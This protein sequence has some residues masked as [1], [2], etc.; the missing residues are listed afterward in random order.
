MKN[1]DNEWEER[2][3]IE[4]RTFQ[5]CGQQFVMK[6]A[7]KPELMAA[8]DNVDASAPIEESMGALD[9]LFLAFIEHDD[10]AEARYRA[11]RADEQ[12]LGIRDIEDI[13]DWMIEAQ[14]G[15][16]PTSRGASTAGAEQLGTRSM[17]ASRSPALSAVSG[18]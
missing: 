3:S 5:V 11:L 17:G 15:R 12:E 18:A 4:A 16:P 8:R 7:V 2:R 9:D 6:K 10:D 1:F 14:T 13:L